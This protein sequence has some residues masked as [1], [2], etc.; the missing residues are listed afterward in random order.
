L[1]EKGPA[2]F[3]RTDPEDITP[4]D[5]WRYLDRIGAVSDAEFD[6]YAESAGARGEFAGLVEEVLSEY[7]ES[8]YCEEG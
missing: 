4:G 3:G 6:F 8:L 1:K 2:V 7:E 5:A